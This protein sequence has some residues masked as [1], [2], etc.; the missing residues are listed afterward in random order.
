[1]RKIQPLKVHINCMFLLLSGCWHKREKAP[2]L[3]L[4]FLTVFFFFQHLEGT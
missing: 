2:E 4:N 1:M 3:R